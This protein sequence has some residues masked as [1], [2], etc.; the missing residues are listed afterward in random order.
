MHIRVR[1]RRQKGFLRRGFLLFRLWICQLNA[2][3]QE[4]G[5]S[6]GVAFSIEF[7]HKADRAATLVRGVVKPLTAVYRD[8]V[9]ACQP[10]LPPGFDELFALVKEKFF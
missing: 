1:N 6:F 7:L 5:H 4:H 3:A 2:I 10:L 8:A 9:V